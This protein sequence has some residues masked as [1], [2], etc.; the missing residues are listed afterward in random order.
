MGS[1]GI[2]VVTWTDNDTNGIHGQRYSSDG[3]LI[4]AI[5]RGQR[6]NRR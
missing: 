6:L 1:D 3:D 2:Y 4:G 5:F